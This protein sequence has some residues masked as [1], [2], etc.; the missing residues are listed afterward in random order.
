LASIAAGIAPQATPKI[1]TVTGRVARDGSLAMLVDNIPPMKT[2]TGD[3]AI[4]KGWA[5]NNSQIFFGKVKFRD[6]K[7]AL[8]INKAKVIKILD[9]IVVHL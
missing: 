1:I 5:I 3:A 6:N 2:M 9:N 8:A 7:K 4:T